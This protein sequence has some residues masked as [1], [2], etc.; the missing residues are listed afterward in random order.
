MLSKS[1]LLL[2]TFISTKI[3]RKLAVILNEAHFI[4]LQ[5]RNNLFKEQPCMETSLNCKCTF[6]Y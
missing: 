6:D 3:Y 1:K 4:E 5:V 2:V